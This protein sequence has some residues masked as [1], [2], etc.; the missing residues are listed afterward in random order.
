MPKTPETVRLLREIRER[1]ERGE[2]PHPLQSWANSAEETHR[3]RKAIY[4][5]LGIKHD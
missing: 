4:E 5:M 2:G 3:S 1:Y